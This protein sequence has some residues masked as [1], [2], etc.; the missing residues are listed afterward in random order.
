MR[1]TSTPGDSKTRRTDWS[2]ATARMPA[3]FAD[4]PRR[5]ASVE[6]RGN[7]DGLDLIEAAAG[8]AAL[9]AIAELAA[10]NAAAETV[11]VREP[12]VIATQS[13]HEAASEDE[14]PDDED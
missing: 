11:G 8:A 13:E 5:D 14:D 4:Q 1:P 3:S 2:R 6:G 12:D 7:D 10:G 9:A